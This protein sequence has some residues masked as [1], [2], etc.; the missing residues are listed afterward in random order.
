[1]NTPI[2]IMITSKPYG[3]WIYPGELHFPSY[4]ICVPKNDKVIQILLF[5][6][7]K[8]GLYDIRF[9][10]FHLLWKNV[11]GSYEKASS[12]RVEFL[13]FGLSLWCVRAWGNCIF[14]FFL[15][16]ILSSKNTNDTIINLFP[17]FY[18]TAILLHNSICCDSMYMVIL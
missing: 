10:R 8:Y 11:E 13:V 5:G 14:M 15:H 17:I 18:V 7:T 12:R 1:M 3:E 6:S 4:F 16:N 2:Y 9:G